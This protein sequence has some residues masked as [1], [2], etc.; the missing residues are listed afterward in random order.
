MSEE[1][2][3]V[4]FIVP[5]WGEHDAIVTASSYD[6]AVDLALAETGLDESEVEVAYA[7]VAAAIGA[8]EPAEEM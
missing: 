1:Q 5:G 6:E 7:T 8:R 3:M 2:W 4:G